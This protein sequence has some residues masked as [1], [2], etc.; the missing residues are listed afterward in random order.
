MN[1]FHRAIVFAV[2][3]GFFFAG[4]EA[5]GQ[6]E[7]GEIEKTPEA[8][9]YEPK[10]TR[11]PPEVDRKLGS[12]DDAAKSKSSQIG[13]SIMTRKEAR[14]FTFSIPAPRGQILDRFGHPLAQNTVAYYAA[15]N[16]PYLPDATD[17]DILRYAGE[18]IIHANDL[19]G[20]QWD[21]DGKTVVEHYRN[22]RWLPLTFSSPL[23]EEQFVD[24]DRQRKP[25]LVLHPVYLRHY[26]NEKMLSHVLGYVGERPPRKLGPI[27]PNEPLWRDGK[28]VEGLEEQF[29]QFLT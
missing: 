7:L 4:A 8:A 20:A 13:S 22:R 17:E 24:L 27:E 12:N 2:S 26:P 28:G 29:D 23:T 11:K 19:L 25:G 14:T 5:L 6:D 16:F 18:R 15:I 10:D 9:D 1:F 3:G 21:L